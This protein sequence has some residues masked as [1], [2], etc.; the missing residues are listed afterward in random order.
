M[1]AGPLYPAVALLPLARVLLLLAVAL[2]AVGVSL[3]AAASRLAVVEPLP[4]SVSPL[5]VAGLPPLVSESPLAVVSPS[6]A[7]LPL[8]VAT[9]SLSAAV[10]PL[11]AVVA[12]LCRRYLCH[13]C[14]HSRGKR[15]LRRLTPL[16]PPCEAQTA[17]LRPRT[18][19]PG[20][21]SPP[22]P[23]LPLE[24]FPQGPA[25]F[26]SPLPW[27]SP[28][29]FPCRRSSSL[30]RWGTVLPSR[31][32]CWA[33]GCTTGG[34]PLGLPCFRP[35]GSRQSILGGHPLRPPRSVEGLWPLF[36]CGPSSLAESHGLSLYESVNCRSLSRTPPLLLS[37][38]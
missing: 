16:R 37:H 23:S 35:T 29:P 17:F 22:F 32:R 24:I 11:W 27:Q 12:P 2:R 15:C 25:S 8:W 1:A 19:L 10:M 26:S 5:P 30:A 33:V 36:F 14:R 31:H 6:V 28:Q 21:Q 38:L 34:P 7:G 20:E 13:P 18:H 9:A 3:P 4:A